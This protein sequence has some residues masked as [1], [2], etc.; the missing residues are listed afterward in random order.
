MKAL[1]NKSYLNT[2]GDP[3]A[4]CQ[5]GGHLLS[6]FITGP[7]LVISWSTGSYFVCGQHMQ[8]SVEI[9]LGRALAGCPAWK[10]GSLLVTQ[11]AH[12]P[13]QPLSSFITF[14]KQTI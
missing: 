9:G 12:F 11:A 3:G 2:F 7:E 6:Y 10:Q 1:V 14:V 8:V 4:F 5:G 13:I